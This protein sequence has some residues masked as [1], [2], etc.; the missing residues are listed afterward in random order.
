MPGTAG[1]AGRFGARGLLRAVK[2][3]DR[4]EGARRSSPSGKTV[5][6][7]TLR[8]PSEQEC[9]RV[10][11]L[12]H[13]RGMASAIAYRDPQE[14]GRSPIFV[15]VMDEVRAM[16]GFLPELRETVPDAR[17]SVTREEVVHVSPSDFLRGG[18][19]RPGPFRVEAGGLGWVFAGGTLGGGARILTE[20]AA[21]YASPSYQFPWGTMAVNVLGSFAIAILGTLV[22][23][24]FVGERVRM[25]WVLGFLGSFTTFSSFALQT[26]EGWESSPILGGL[27]GGGS[28][29]L[30]LAAALLGLRLARRALRW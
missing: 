7:A 3:R 19:Y 6:Q 12:S 11:R 23:E 20:S 9:E 29:L 13:E 25:F 15:L 21:R 28:I 26:T 17:I 18:A 10:I 24:R 1:R 14:D 4:R 16:E 5:A 2:N 8:L 30:G 27:Y 22:A